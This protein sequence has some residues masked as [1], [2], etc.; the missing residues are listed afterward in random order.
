MHP[1]I[2]HLLADIKAAHRREDEYGGFAPPASIEEEL[3]E[4]ERWVAGPEPEHTF[5]YYCGLK[6][7]D[8]PPAEQLSNQDLRCVC[9]A[10]QELLFT[11]NADISLP[12][13]LPLPLKYR[14][15]VNTLDEG[16]T[17]VN[18]GFMTF[19]YCS[20]YAPECPFKEYCPC[21][22]IWNKS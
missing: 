12:E 16:F 2:P 1:Y 9:K 13:A 18:S 7:A 11:W 17:V 5:G 15:M 6:S 20:G 21:L 10:F 4:I 22:E 19:D 8:F 3:E 14:F